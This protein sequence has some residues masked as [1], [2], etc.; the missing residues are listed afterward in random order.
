MSLDERGNLSLCSVIQSKTCSCNGKF[1]ENQCQGYNAYA[2][3]SEGAARIKNVVGLR[4]SSAT[5]S[6]FNPLK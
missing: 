5:Y 4:L 1:D 6:K 2:W 3:P